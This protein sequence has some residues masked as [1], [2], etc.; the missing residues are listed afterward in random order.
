LALL[1]DVTRISADPAARAEVNPLLKRL[2]LWIGLTFRPAVKGKKRVVQRLV[3]G[4]IV[5]GDGL[6][7]VPLFGKDNVDDGPAS[8]GCV[9]A[10]PVISATDNEHEQGNPATDD[11]A[12]GPVRSAEKSEDGRQEKQ[13]AGT[14][15]FPVPAAD[16]GDRSPDR[17][18]KSQPEGISITKV[19]RGERIRTSDL[20]NP[21]RGGEAKKGRFSEDFFGSAFSQFPS[22]TAFRSSSQGSYCPY[23]PGPFQHS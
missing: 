2:G 13:P 1:D 17:L 21:I 10:A 5:F 7:P 15:V 20:L 8:C 9:P 22:F 14:G 18:N 11:L 12:G 23:C 6:L 19:S 4:R 16:L 3:S